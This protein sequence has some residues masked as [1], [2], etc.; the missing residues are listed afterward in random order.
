MTE[1][2]LKEYHH[3]I[4]LLCIYLTKVDELKAWKAMLEEEL[5]KRGV[6]I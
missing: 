2:L 5:K 4:G 3:V 1:E 6:K